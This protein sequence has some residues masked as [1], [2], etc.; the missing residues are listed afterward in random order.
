MYY[1]EFGCEADVMKEFSIGSV[2]GEIIFA[3]YEY[4]DYSGSAEVIFIRNGKFYHVSGSHCSCY[5]LEDQWNPEEMP[6]EA[7]KHIAEKATYGM[8]AQMRSEIV[9]AI[10]GALAKVGVTPEVE[11]SQAQFALRI[12]FR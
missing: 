6:Y 7:L 5:G 2:E 3:A 9:A 10:D 8:L 11:A 4:E 12:A 1:G